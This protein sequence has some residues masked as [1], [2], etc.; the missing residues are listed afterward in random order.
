MGIRLSFAVFSLFTILFLLVC[1]SC[2][3]KT[4]ET[5]NPSLFPK[6]FLF[7]AATSSY[8]VEGAVLEDGKGLNNWDIFTHEPGKITDGSNGDIAIDHYHRFLEDIELMSYLGLDSYRFSISWARIL[9]RGRFGGINEAGINFYNKFIDALLLKGIQPFVTLNHFDI[10]QELEDRYGSWLNSE[11]Q[12]DFG[13]FADVCFGAFGDRVKY[14]VT[15]NEPNLYTI[16]GYRLG[17]YPPA[18]C[19]KPFG[20]CTRGDS[21]TEPFV[22]AHNFILCHAVAVDIYRTK[23]QKEQGGSIGIVMSARWFEPLSNNSEDVAA[24]QRAL[25]FYMNWILDP[26]ILGKYP[27]EMHEILG[28]ILPTFSRKDREKLRKGLDFIGLNHY[29]GVYVK[30]CL[31]SACEFGNGNTKSE[32]FIYETKEKDGIFIGEPTVM[33]WCIYPQGMEKIVLYIMDRYSNIPV[34]I[35]ENGFADENHP[36]VN[37]G[38][39]LHDVE[40]VKYI[41]GYLDALAT[42]IRK[43]ADVR[44]YFAWSLFD[45]FEWIFGY[46][47]RFGLIFVDLETLNRTPKLSANWYKQFIEKHKTNKSMI[48]ENIREYLEGRR[49]GI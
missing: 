22:V 35:T 47:K 49:D 39:F 32:G 28:S 14:W 11:I 27:A 9:P 2:D 4:E 17:S 20:N 18:Y 33:G 12:E 6:G 30:D 3:P 48:A 31:F 44:G 43:G 10:P 34:F 46:T 29:S 25:S 41:S 23:Y 13:Y 21:D 15:L 45:N 24:A 19:S 40:R 42:A 37:I 5:E 26:I 8:Q 38:S 36:N 16:R 7:G 1:I